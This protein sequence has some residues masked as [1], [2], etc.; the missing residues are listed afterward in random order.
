VVRINWSPDSAELR[1]WAYL[2]LP[3]L[4]AVGALFHF[5]DWGPFAGGQRFAIF[6]WSFA[7]F[8]FLTA[9]TGTRLGWP[10]YRAWMGFVYVVGTVIGVTALA[11]VYFLV[12][13][14]MALLGRAVGRD[15]LQ[16][17]GRGAA[18]FWHRLDAEAPHNPERQF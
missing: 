9:V 5:V 7:V 8:A 4:A 10:A 6:L 17:R 11:V 2:I 15:R 13:T 1:R 3:V 18:T 16:L 12:L 14:P